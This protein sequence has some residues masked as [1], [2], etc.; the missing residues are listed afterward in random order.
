MSLPPLVV[1]DAG[2]IRALFEMCQRAGAVDAD[3]SIL[4]Y[5]MHLEVGKFAQPLVQHRTTSWNIMGTSKR[6]WRRFRHRI[7]YVT[8]TDVY[9]TSIA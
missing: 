4:D 3:S 5:R 2:E 7:V 6:R 8:Y 9:P 1:A